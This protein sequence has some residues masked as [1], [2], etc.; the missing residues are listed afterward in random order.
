MANVWM[1]LLRV[2]YE[3]IKSWCLF[4][5][6][7]SYRF[8]DVSQDTVLITGGGSGIGRL[9]AQR[10]AAL[11]SR[12]VILDVNEAGMKETA[13]LITKS[14]GSCVYYVCDV[15]NRQHVFSIAAK[16]RDE[17]GF[18]SI[19]VNNA[20]ITGCGSRFLELND[21]RIIKTMEVNAFSQFWVTKAFLPDMVERNQGHVVFVASYAGLVGGC[22]LA[23]Y[24]ASKFAVMGLAESVTLELK[25]DGRNINTTAVCPY[26]ID[27]GLFHGAAGSKLVPTLK[28]D[29]AAD[30]IMD[31]IRLNQYILVMPQSLYLTIVVKSLIPVAA[32]FELYKALDGLSF[33]QGF[34]GRQNNNNRSSN[35]N[36]Q[37]KGE[38]KAA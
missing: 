13:S 32:A 17:V 15:S 28:P 38:K 22:N 37:S 8:K 29:H 3:W 33:M 9:M 4:C 24:S 31:A 21:E 30:R 5:V 14:N 35:S 36:A 1:G 16:I 27:T 2:L 26:L 34:T 18:V 12:V 20:G 19:L 7:N 11:G 23:D 25:A 10:F 6:P